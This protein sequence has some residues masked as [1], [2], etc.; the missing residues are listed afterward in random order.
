MESSDSKSPLLDLV[1]ET[2]RLRTLAKSLSSHTDDVRLSKRATNALSRFDK[3]FFDNLKLLG[4]EV[5]DFTGTIYDIG[6][7]VHPINLEDFSSEDTLIIEMMIEPVV[8]EFG[9][10]NIL[11]P[12][13]VALAK[14]QS[15]NNA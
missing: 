4:M 13:V 7:P 9:T 11:K 15:A 3:H 12:G 1:V 14:I 6:L 2:Y 10:A 5:L 8:K